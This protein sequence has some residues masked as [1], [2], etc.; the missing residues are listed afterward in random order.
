M[1]RIQTTHWFLLLSLVTI[2]CVLAACGGD[3][4]TPTKAP[5]P[6]TARRTLAPT[7]A[8]GSTA[9]GGGAQPTTDTLD[10]SA[11]STGDV[12]EE[13]GT[14][15]TQDNLD[16]SSGNQDQPTGAPPAALGPNVQDGKVVL[17]DTLWNLDKDKELYRFCKAGRWDV[18]QGG[19][20]VVKTGTFKSD[21][22]N[23]TVT[24]N[25]DKKAVKYQVAYQADAKTLELKDGASTLNLK[26][27]GNA[28]CS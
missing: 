22:D 6:T 19:S 17:A 24:N 5:A 20:T 18:L 2:V 14:E 26:Y 27:S 1:K 10:D 25:A 21:G 9:T 28:N 16:D 3:S 4:P 7:R 23:V 15:P 11:G 8:Q 13:P 12:T